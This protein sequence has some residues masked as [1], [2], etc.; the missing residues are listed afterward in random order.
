MPWTLADDFDRW[1]NGVDLSWRDD[2]LHRSGTFRSAATTPVV[3]LYPDGGS[4]IPFEQAGYAADSPRHFS[5]PTLIDMGAPVYRIVVHGSQAT[6]R[7]I[8]DFSDVDIAVILDDS[9]Q[10]SPAELR[11]AV[12]GLRGLLRAV[13]AYDSLMHHGLMFYPRSGLDAYDQSFLPLETLK[14]SRTL[15]GDCKLEVIQ[16]SANRSALASRLRNS[17]ASLRRNFQR[18]DYRRSDFHLKRVLSGILLLPASVL[19]TQGCFV[20]KGESFALAR[21]LFTA[22]QWELIGRAEDIRRKWVR[23]PKSPLGSFL[24]SWLH[25]RHRIT[26]EKR[27]PPRGNTLSLFDSRSDPLADSAS[28]CLERLEYIITEHSPFRARTT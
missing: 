16:V 7:A 8:L 24:T 18:G 4:P 26:W 12:V 11:R 25:P 14:R 17:I 1:V 15:V 23:P 21:E 19:A 5:A 20:Y 3:P 10:H 2:L 13:Y 22:P 27:F 6:D 9:K 28:A